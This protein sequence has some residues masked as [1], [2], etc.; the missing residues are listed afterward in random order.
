VPGA[1]CFCLVGV[2]VLPVTARLVSRIEVGALH[3]DWVLCEV[4]VRCWS[5]FSRAINAHEK[6][7]PT[8]QGLFFQIPLVVDTT[9]YTLSIPLLE[10]RGS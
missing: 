10:L 2:A 9:A 8:D 5:W 3:A 4:R 1:L 6:V 7:F